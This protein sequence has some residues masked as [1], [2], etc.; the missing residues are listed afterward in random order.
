MKSTIEV[1]DFS[2]VDVVVLGDIMLDEYIWGDV[3]RISPEA[4]VPVVKVDTVTYRLGG[5][6]NVAANLAGLGCRVTFVGAV[7]NDRMGKKIGRLLEQN[8]ISDHT[9]AFDSL[10]TIRKT[11]VMGVGQQLVRIDRENP[12]QI[13]NSHHEQLWQKFSATIE[14][15]ANTTLVILSD[16][17]KGVLQSN[18]IENCIAFCRSNQLPIFVDPKAENWEPY[19][20]ATC[21]TPNE[22]E[23]A[24]IHHR[25]GTDT[26]SDSLQTRGAKVREAFD[27]D[28]LLV[29][30][31]AKGMCLFQKEKDALSIPSKARE[32]FDVSGA[33]D[34][35][36]AVLAASFAAGCAMPMA[37]ELANTAAEVAVGKVGTHAISLGELQQ[38]LR[39]LYEG[40]RHKIC[41]LTQGTDI[42]NEWRG[43]QEKIVFTNGCFDLLHTGHIHLLQSAAK[44]GDRLIVGLN[45][46]TSIRKLK[47]PSRPVLAEE[48]RAAILA[49]LECVDMV[50]LFAEPTPLQLIETIRP[51]V[52]VKGCDY[53]KNEVVGA[54]LVESWGGKVVL[55]PLEEG[56]STSS[57]IRS[58]A[59]GEQTTAEP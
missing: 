14:T 7:S 1:P 55:F 28:W 45:T 56:K 35:V 24:A 48:D 8:G 53:R 17:G 38:A 42:S 4:P 22:K 51:D 12:E 21:V 27:L 36:I 33:G 31:G 59:N 5:A 49:A 46:D 32:V 13:Q 50:V 57:L 40:P 25:L 3:A 10:S 9:V 6:G 16:Y 20:G 19:R 29:T 18:L 2:R 54:D 47:G 37:M 43:R 34:T 26:T 58:I 41:S 11:R 15:A 30:R 23:L 44:E 39:L 52:I